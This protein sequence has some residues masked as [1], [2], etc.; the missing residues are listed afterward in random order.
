[1]FEAVELG[2][3]VSKKT[4]EKELPELRTRLI[5]AQNA[6]QSYKGPL[7]VIFHGLDGA[8]KGELMN[9]IGGLMDLRDIE[10]N[11]FW[12]ETEAESKRPP[13]WKYWMSI[14]QRGHISFSFG[15]WYTGPMLS[16]VKN[17][18]DIPVFERQ[19]KRAA[20]FEETL[21]ND[22]AIILK[23]WF[24]LSKKS[25]KGK[26]DV[27]KKKYGKGDIYDRAM[28]HREKYDAIVNAAERGIRITDS[29]SSR[30]HLVEADDK[31]HRTKKVLEILTGTM[32]AALK[33][34]EAGVSAQPPGNI[35]S[36]PP[37]LSRIDLSNSLD[38]GEYKKSLAKHQERLNTLAWEVYNQGKSVI[39]MFE[40]WDAGGK[41]GAIRR[42]VQG[43]DIRLVSVHSVAAPTREEIAHHYLWR[44]WRD[45]PREG[46]I[47]IYDRSW[48]GRVLVE[49]VEG[50]ASPQEWGR[51][52][53][54][55]NDFEEQL[56]ES[57]II[58]LKFWMHISPEEQLKRF[59][60]REEL[61]WKQY[62]IT[63]EDYRN[64]E[65]W[66]LYEDAANE[67]IARTSTGF[68]PWTLV[69]GDDKRYARI[70][71]METFCEKL[72][73]SL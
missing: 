50:F 54:E 13:F 55:I 38:K 42:L 14:P 44:F 26:L 70:K 73:G 48:Y 69:A 20:R 47:S 68:S 27:L 30:W 65:K 46:F 53:E 61:P 63:E 6:F 67:M 5:R 58:L 71:V 45:I 21:A 35:N 51:S 28:W 12:K 24:H 60:Q 18:T 72:E 41:G 34:E 4:F 49:R 66:E 29:A 25:A 43:M 40:G 23:F 52:Y 39:A 8:G 3:K 7:M 62:K 2:Q 1:M 59:K 32:E 15:A 22:G 17:E 31:W 11:T 16:L 9:Y 56:T 36:A 19:M 57:G 10:I 33:K 64:R 37:V